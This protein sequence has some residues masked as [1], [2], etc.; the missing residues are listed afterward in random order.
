LKNAFIEIIQFS[1]LKL[2]HLRMKI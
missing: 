2:R 1:A